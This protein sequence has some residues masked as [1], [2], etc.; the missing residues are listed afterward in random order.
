MIV[1]DTS[2][3]VDY[4][5]DLETPQTAWLEAELG[6]NHLAITD[7]I[8]CEILQGVRDDKEYRE[9]RE[10]LFQLEI[11]PTGGTNLALAAVDNY[12]RLRKKGLTVRKTIDCLIATFCILNGH[13]LLHSDR[14][15]DA[16]EKELGLQVIHP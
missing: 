13:S 4:T 6:R 5:R 8:L 15:F 7:L 16:F 10:T 14:D 2:V 1:V 9:T 3:W 11:F 12:R